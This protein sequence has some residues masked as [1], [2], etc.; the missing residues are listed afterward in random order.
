M[1]NNTVRF[2]LIIVLALFTGTLFGIWMGSNPAKLSAAA[3]VELMQNTIRHL[4]P[5]MQVLG[6][7]SI[8]LTIT[9]AILSKERRERYLLF[10]AAGFIVVTAVITFVVN[11]PINTELM[12]WSVD[13]P[14][15]NWMELRDKW[16]SGH[17]ARTLT[18]IAGLVFAVLAVIG[19]RKT[20]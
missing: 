10:A 18:A 2:I 19:S 17:I 15:A 5:V 16:W 9:L 12:S 1:I 4:G 7:L 14:A 20:H 11:Q 8:V 6:P 3:Y 13:A